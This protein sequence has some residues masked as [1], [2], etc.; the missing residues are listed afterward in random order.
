MWVRAAVVRDPICRETS[1]TRV[2]REAERARTVAGN[3]AEGY[4]F[5]CGEAA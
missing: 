3:I 1:L 4:G 2:Q 5:G